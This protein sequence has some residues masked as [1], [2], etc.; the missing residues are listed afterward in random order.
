[1]NTPLTGLGWTSAANVAPAGW[2]AIT[3]TVEGVSANFGKG[4]AQKSG[5]YLCFTS[6]INCANPT[7]DIISD[8][9]ILSDKSPLPSGY[10]Y[11]K[12][13][14]DPK[15]SVSKKK[16]LCVKVIPL[17]AADL[18][19]LE[20][21]VTSKSK[22]LPNYLRIGEMSGFA[23]WCKKDHVLKPKPL[24][25]PRKINLEMKHLS[26]EPDNSCGTDAP[27][28]R[29]P[30]PFGPKR[31]ATLKHHESIYESSNVYAISAMDGVPFALHP[32]FENSDSG[33]TNASSFFK[34]FHIKSLTDIEKEY[35]YSFVV[36]RTAAARLPPTIS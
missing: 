3:T 28:E 35:D 19:V 26:L 23:L 22:L 34:D 15:S 11:V 12:E 32:K 14:L 20:I 8:V 29:P 13:F 31:Q 18:A 5:Y 10:V 30:P 6:A 9:V 7:G 1:M 17:G 36:E 4:F 2:T 25:K 16:R 27:P 33:S 24:P 21:L